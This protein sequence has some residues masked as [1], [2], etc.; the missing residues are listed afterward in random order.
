MNIQI[1]GK[2]FDVTDAIRSHTEEKASRLPRYYS[3]IHEIEII[4]GTSDNGI[5]AEVIVRC[6]HGHVFVATEKG[7]A[8]K[9]LYTCIDSVF[10]K[11]ERQLT[12]AKG[13]ERNPKHAAKSDA[14]AG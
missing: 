1:T 5:F 14:L 6:G 4:Y 12:K 7:E 3:S 13:K 10:H 11:M 9:D 2:H 8:K